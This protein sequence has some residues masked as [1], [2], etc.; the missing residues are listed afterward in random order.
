VPYLPLDGCDLYYETHGAGP[1]VVFAHGGAGN[2]LSF[3]E[4][5]PHFNDRYQVVTFSQRGCGLSRESRDSRGPVAFVDDLE[6][7]LAHLEIE[8][9]RLVAQSM[10]GW[11]FLDYALRHPERVKALV[12]A[13]TTGSLTHPE[14]DRILAE[15]A[16]LGIRATLGARGILPACGE[17]MAREQPALHFLY[18]QAAAL[19][20]TSEA[21]DV[22][23]RLQPL[24]TTPPEALARLTMPVLCITGEED[25]LQP[26]ATVEIMASLIPDARCVRVPEAGHSVYWERAE[27]FNRLVDEFLGDVS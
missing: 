1:A 18:G 8:E 23:N 13:A 24:R 20:T 17:R 27:L 26:S 19:N 5:V 3:W 2:Q 9:V 12:L 16:A 25:V 7:L 4:Q 6:A 21:G 15:N 11:I 14:I 10:G 22:N